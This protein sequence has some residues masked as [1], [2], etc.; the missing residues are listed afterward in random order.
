MRQ[1]YHNVH[2]LPAVRL[3][4]H[5]AMLEQL[6]LDV[7]VNNGHFILQ[8]FLIIANFSL[9][10]PVIQLSQYVSVWPAAIS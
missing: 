9:Y 3:A 10:L 6:G 5:V 2:T 8:P 4:Y 1:I 7:N